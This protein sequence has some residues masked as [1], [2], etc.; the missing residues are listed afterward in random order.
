MRR[1]FAM[2]AAFVVAMTGALVTKASKTTS[3]FSISDCTTPVTCDV[4]TKTPCGVVQ[5]AC[6]TVIYKK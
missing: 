2:I 5:S 3:Y 6:N 1:K 4:G